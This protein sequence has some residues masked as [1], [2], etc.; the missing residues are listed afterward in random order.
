MGIIQTDAAII[1]ARHY[2]K[3][4]LQ[5]LVG[6]RHVYGYQDGKNK[7]KQ[8]KREQDL[9]EGTEGFAHETEVESRKSEAETVMAIMF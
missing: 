3:N 4:E 7:K 5:S 9:A 6:W 8:E 1:L 2:L